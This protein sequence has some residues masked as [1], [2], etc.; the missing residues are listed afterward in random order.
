MLHSVAGFNTETLFV[1]VMQWVQ[2]DLDSMDDIEAVLNAMLAIK[3]FV[4]VANNPHLTAERAIERTAEDIEP[5][6]RSFRIGIRC[7]N[8]PH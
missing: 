5:I 8:F 1:M 3:A 6:M 7:S 4:V 2:C